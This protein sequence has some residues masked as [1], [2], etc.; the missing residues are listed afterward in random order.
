VDHHR[1]VAKKQSTAQLLALRILP[2]FQPLNQDASRRRSSYCKKSLHADSRERANRAPQ[3]IHHT[4]DNFNIQPDKL[5]LG[6]INES[7]STLQQS[8]ELR[9][10]DAENALRK[11]SR[12]LS[13]LSSQHRETIS[14]HDS[15]TH[16]A[17][18]SELDTKKF[19]IAKAASEVEI[20]NERLEGDLETLK[21]RLAD[22]E[23]QGLEGDDQA[24][25][26][27]EA[28]DATM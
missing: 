23:M 4:I 6:R 25:R 26:E 14:A 28:D 9:I 16:A 2:N 7:L 17:E 5:A 22:L 11:L 1:D 21:A 3:L 13:T 15:V 27:R 18:I 24:R 12:N 10:R 8:R 19:R 20:E